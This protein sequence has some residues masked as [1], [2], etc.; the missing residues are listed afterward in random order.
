MI[1]KVKAGLIVTD[2]RSLTHP[3]TAAEKRFPSEV[4]L[5]VHPNAKG[6]SSIPIL[7]CLPERNEIPD[8]GAIPDLAFQ[9]CFSVYAIPCPVSEFAIEPAFD[10]RYKAQLGA[11]A[12]F[13]A[14]LRAWPRAG[15][16]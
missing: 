10:R 7:R 1:S 15:S 12:P 6:V 2:C 3:R 9:E 4:G 16:A 8:C 11:F 5:Q 13:P 14:A